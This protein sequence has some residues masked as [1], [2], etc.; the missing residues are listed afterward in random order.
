MRRVLFLVSIITILSIII[1]A[2][3]GNPGP[4]AAG[5]D[6][7]QPPA[8]DVPA[9]NPA[10]T[11]A[12]VVP[13]D[14][15]GPPMEVGSKYTYIDGSILAAVPGG[16]FLMGN[17]N[18]G[19]SPEK[20]VTLGDFWIY[21]SEV[22]NA[23]FALCVSTGQCTAPDPE[24][25][26]NFSNYRFTNLPVVGV[27]Y[28]QAADYCKFVHG[29]LPTEAEWE[30]AARGPDGNV[31][32]WGDAAPTCDLLN[33]NFCK[34]KLEDVQ[35]YPSGASFY[36]VFDM[37][38]NV[39]EW[40]ADWY[41]S[42][43]Y[44]N[45][46]AEDPLGP[47]L[48]EKRSI[49]S[50]SFADGADASISAHRYSLKPIESLPDLGFRCVVDNPVELA[51]M[52]TQLASY[53]VDINGQ[54]SSCAPKVI[55][56]DVN[57]NQ[58][59]SCVKANDPYTIVQFSMANNPPD[60]WTHN[61]PTGCTPLGGDKYECHPGDGPDLTAQGSCSIDNSCGE[62][63]CPAHYKKVGDSCQWDGTG[64]QGTQCPVGASYDSLGKCCVADSGTGTNFNLC[65]AGFYELN[66]VCVPN[67]SGQI[68][69][70]TQT[71]QFD[72]CAPP[73]TSG[74]DEPTPPPGS[75]IP[76]TSCPIRGQKWDPAT[77]TCH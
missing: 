69:T 23:Q 50:T 65:P 47:D 7:T 60:G 70:E 27:N 36:G 67:G 29:R 66:G 57:V 31:F 48:G 24:K 56:N 13:I 64:T 75:C 34:G 72:Q 15:A 54:P 19:D 4:G 53:S 2:C 63:G 58:G 62:P 61:D 68:D 28:Q 11:D 59:M 6:A 37:A 74:G 32:P 30:K 26:P 73:E 40:V 17:N 76:V 42:N 43:Y 12:P 5:V 45:G 71:L 33:F 41:D 49:R 21:S 39:R 1:V 18:M 16:E 38:G 3:G 77:C 8:T 51:P 46:S 44:T 55:C 22:T 35:S 9:V 10:A 52:C 25:N 14:L 20:K